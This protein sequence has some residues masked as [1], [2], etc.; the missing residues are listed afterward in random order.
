MRKTRSWKHNT[1]EAKQYGKR[2]EE[3]YQSDF[4]MLDEKYLKDEEESEN[5]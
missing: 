1:K 4:M 2:S 5:V 3:R